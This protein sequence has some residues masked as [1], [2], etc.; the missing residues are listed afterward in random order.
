MS[1]GGISVTVPA[2][3]VVPSPAPTWPLAIRRQEVAVHVAGAP[4]HRVAGHDVLGDRGFEEALGR[5]DLD[6]ARGHVGLVDHAP[7]AA[8]VVDVAVGVDH[9]L[10]R[11]L[12]AVGV[13]EIEAHLR[14]FRRDQRID[15]GDAFPS[16]DDGHVRQVE[17]ADLVEAVRDLEQAAE[18]DELRLSPQA[19]IDGIR[20]R[21]IRPDEAVLL[22]VPDRVAGLALDHVG[23]QGRDEAAPGI[24]EVRPV[25]ERQLVE[26]P[27]VGRLGRGG[28]VLAQ[29]LRGSG[30]GHACDQAQ[31]RYDG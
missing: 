13:V 5:V 11:L 6:L 25:G 28:G 18:V 14:G 17:I 4:A 8:V 16:L 9:R 2:E 19:R 1:V 21:G 29:I 23:R 3:V 31:D 26:Q 20:G 10:D 15:D 12:P 30:A 27:L 22:R 24:L 7:D